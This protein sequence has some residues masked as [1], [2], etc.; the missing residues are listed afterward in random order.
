MLKMEAIQVL[1]SMAVN[2]IGALAGMKKGPQADALTRQVEAITMAQAALKEPPRA[3]DVR[4]ETPLGALIVKESYDAEHPG[5][6]IDL[7]RPDVGNDAPLALVEFA[8]DDGDFPEGEPHIISR[9]WGDAM[10]E[11]YTT[12]VVHD[13]IEEFFAIEDYDEED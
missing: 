2:A 9:I 4:V 3:S 1:E 7:R 6:Y 13:N 8:K 10:D 12:R 11:S 5:I